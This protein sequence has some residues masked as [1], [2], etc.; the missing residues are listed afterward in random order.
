[1]CTRIRTRDAN[2]S[3]SGSTD[4]DHGWGG[5]GIFEYG[6]KGLPHALVHA[7]E[8]V[9]TGGHHGAYCSSVAEAVHKNAIKRAAQFSRTLGSKNDTHENMLGWVLRHQMYD[10]V[11]KL[12]DRSTSPQG[13]R[14]SSSSN[15]EDEDE[16]Q[17]KLWT[18]LDYCRDWQELRSSQATN[19]ISARW[20]STCVR[21]RVIMFVYERGVYAHS[22]SYTCNMFLSPDL[23]FVYV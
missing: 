3:D 13:R 19:V 10:D 14:H 18:P 2:E 8:L 12:H 4:D 1:M 17:H 16:R 11:E 20:G 5:L 15:G 22:R 9:E 23:V 6:R 7:R 21:I